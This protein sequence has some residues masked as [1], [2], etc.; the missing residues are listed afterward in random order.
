MNYL[1]DTHAL[2]WSVQE[3]DKLSKKARAVIEN[4]ENRLYVSA[5]SAFEIANKFRIGKLP[6]YEHVVENY[7]QIVQKLGASDLP[8]TAEQGHFAAKFE[9]HHRDPFDRIIAAQA[10]IENMILI[11]CDEV[12]H[13]LPWVE[14]LW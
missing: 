13:T 5:I 1:L 2:L 11:S 8:I 9:W 3:D 6:Q 4:K 7:V 12:F 10:S 14:V